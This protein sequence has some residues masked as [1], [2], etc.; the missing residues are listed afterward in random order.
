MVQREPSLTYILTSTGAKGT[1][2]VGRL[3]LQLVFA[4]G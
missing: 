2:E 4:L 3:D 1:L